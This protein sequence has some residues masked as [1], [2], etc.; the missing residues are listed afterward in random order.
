MVN[1]YI[2]NKRGNYLN[3]IGAKIISAS[4]RKMINLIN[5]NLNLA[6]IINILKLKL[7]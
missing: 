3:N 1:D 7:K 6:W 2:K 4:F 5:L